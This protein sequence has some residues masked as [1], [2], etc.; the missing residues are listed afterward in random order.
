M[1]VCDTCWCVLARFFLVPA[2]VEATVWILM[3]L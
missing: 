3:H 1:S 2:A